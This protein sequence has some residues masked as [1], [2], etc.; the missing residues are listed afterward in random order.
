VG[1]ALIALGVFSRSSSPK[2]AVAFVLIAVCLGAQIPASVAI[3]LSQG[4]LGSVA[5]T[6]ALID[7][8]VAVLAFSIV[9]VSVMSR[10]L[11]ER[12][13]GSAVVRAA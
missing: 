2:R 13:A 4:E 1:M 5:I 7:T 10:R 6:D 8:A 12:P 3:S 11:F 9:P